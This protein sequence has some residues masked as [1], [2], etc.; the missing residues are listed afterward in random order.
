[1]F[2]LRRAGIALARA[3]PAVAATRTFTVYAA[4]FGGHGEQKIYQGPGAQAGEIPTDDNQSTGLE[5]VEY[6]NLKE[7]KDI[8]D[9]KPLYVE[10]RG[11]KKNPT[12]IRSR[13]PIRY[14]GCTGV[15][16]ETHEVKWLL[17]D[18]EHDFDRCDECG[19]VYKWTAYE[20]DEYFPAADKKDGLHHH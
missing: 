3:R 12:L 4:R 6:L 14:V 5:R 16:G 7:G 9:L 17:I 15:P 1:M 10:E 11:T 19:N 2:A 18:H 20:P 13:D 8:F